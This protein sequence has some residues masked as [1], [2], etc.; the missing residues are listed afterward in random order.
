MFITA[1]SEHDFQTSLEHICEMEELEQWH[2][3]KGDNGNRS[4][5]FPGQEK[6][7]VRQ[8]KRGH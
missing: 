6:R 5:C 7:P 4:S 2:V 3:T 8:S 1:S